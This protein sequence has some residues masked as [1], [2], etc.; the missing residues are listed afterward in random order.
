VSKKQAEA[1]AGVS[2]VQT[3]FGQFPKA[4][5]PAPTSFPVNVTQA[6]VVRVYALG[7]LPPSPPFPPTVEP[8]FTTGETAQGMHIRSRT[9]DSEGGEL[10]Q[11]DELDELAK[12]LAASQDPHE[13]VPGRASEDGESLKPAELGESASRLAASQGHQES[14]PGR[15]SE[16]DDLLKPA[17]LDELASVLAASQDR[18]LPSVWHRR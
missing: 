9:R 4:S 1:N 18:P 2:I 14:V 13:S 11:P 7:C 3:F 8:R 15:A 10:L 16:D 5:A 17:E 12:R 6:L